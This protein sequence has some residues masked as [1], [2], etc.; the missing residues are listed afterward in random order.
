MWELGMGN[1]EPAYTCILSVKRFSMLY[2][3]L[4]L[5]F[6]S[7]WYSFRISNNICIGKFREKHWNSELNDMT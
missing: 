6:P 1:V 7:F 3:M 5:K 4:R 2:P